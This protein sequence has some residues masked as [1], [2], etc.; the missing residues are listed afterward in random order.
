[1]SG[2]SFIG[3]EPR[4]STTRIVF[5]RVPN[6]STVTLEHSNRYLETT[7]RDIASDLQSLGLPSGGLEGACAMLVDFLGASSNGGL[8]QVLAAEQV[9]LA[10]AFDALY[11]AITQRSTVGA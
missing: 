5:V 2:A 9:R 3:P 8:D 6:A 7:S 11:L 10:E 4:P 1:M